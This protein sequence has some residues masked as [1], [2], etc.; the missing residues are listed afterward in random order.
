M[1]DAESYSQLDGKTQNERK[2]LAR[3]GKSKDING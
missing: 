2:P 1:S 3:D